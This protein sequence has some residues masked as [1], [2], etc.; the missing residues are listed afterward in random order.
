MY[1]PLVNISLMFIC[2]RCSLNVMSTSGPLTTPGSIFPSHSCLQIRSSS[3]LFL[4][5]LLF[6]PFPILF[7]FISFCHFQ[8]LLYWITL[9]CIS[10]L[11]PIYTRLF[12]S[13]LFFKKFLSTFTPSIPIALPNGWHSGPCQSSFLQHKEGKLF[14]LVLFLCLRGWFSCLAS[15]SL[16]RA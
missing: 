8:K 7:G 12:N 4:L 2:T 13:V 3:L 16:P 5:L 15:H 14:C 6:L 1:V 11:S 9:F 10:H